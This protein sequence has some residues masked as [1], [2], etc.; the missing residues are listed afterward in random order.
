M[1]YLTK[2][3]LKDFVVFSR[4][5]CRTPGMGHV[6]LFPLLSAF[7]STCYFLTLL[8][9]LDKVI[10]AVLAPCSVSLS[11]DSPTFLSSL[12]I[13]VVCLGNAIH[14]QSVNDSKL[15]LTLNPDLSVL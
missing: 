4:L 10:S 8:L 15:A 5:V 1:R 13:C 2:S 6:I 7:D 14:A 12:Q 11:S 3:S 9:S